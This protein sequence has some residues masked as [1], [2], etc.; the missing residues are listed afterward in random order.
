MTCSAE[1]C[2]NPIVSRGMCNPHYQKAYREKSLD[3]AGYAPRFKTWT[4]DMVLDNTDNVSGCLL[5][6]DSP[7]RAYP[8]LRHS[9][10]VI[11]VHRFVYE[12]AHGPLEEGIQ[13]HH[14]CAQS[15]CANP[16]HLQRASQADNVLEMLARRD[17][18][19][20]IARLQLKVAALEL[21][22]EREWSNV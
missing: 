22:L 16:E 10:K 21:Q 8:D 2:S 12:L 1:G 20:E 13:V 14:V 7:S 5:W 18:E 3:G 4:L 6:K 9:G 19:T 17:Y 11:K 15:R